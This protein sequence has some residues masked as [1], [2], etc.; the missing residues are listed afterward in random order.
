MLGLN[1]LSRLLA[2]IKRKIFLM[3][4][5]SILSA[6]NDAETTQ[7]LQLKL[8]SDEIVTDIERF[9]NYGHSS[10]P[11][12]DAEALA[13][14]INGNRDHGIVVVVH[15]RRYRPNYLAQGEVVIF[16]DEDKTEAFRVHLKRNRVLNLKCT[17]LDID[18]TNN[19]TKDITKDSTITIGED[20]I[21]TISGAKTEAVT[22]IKTVTAASETITLDTTSETT[23]GTSFT[24][25][26]GSDTM[27]TADGT[28][29]LLGDDVIGSL[30]KLVDERFVA[31]FNAHVHDGVTTGSGDTGAPTTTMTTAAHC[32]D[33]VRGG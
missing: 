11:W 33:K 1:D 2:P 15:D 23:C 3:I 24:V 28:N 20:L 22:G 9:E 6:I 8:L 4:G 26:I 21:T 12:E 14:F 29:L 7:K 19:E 25:I 17:D 10:Y 27:I 18:V 16:T 30:Y 5:R 32:T 13:T 31:L